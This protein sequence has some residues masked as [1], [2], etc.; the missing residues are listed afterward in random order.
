MA[1]KAGTSPATA[2]ELDPTARVPRRPVTDCPRRGRH[3]DESRDPDIMRAALELLAETGYDRLTMEAVAARAKAGKATLYRRWPSKAELVV[4]ALSCLKGPAHA[5]AHDTGSLGG[6]LRASFLGVY[7]D[8]DEFRIGVISGLLTSL[9]RNPDLAKVFEERF[10]TESMRLLRQLFARAR[11]RGEVAD[12]HDIELLAAVG[13]AIL[14]HR[15]LLTGKPLTRDFI[16]RVIDEVIL[17][18]AGNPLPGKAPA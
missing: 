18:L 1:T 12:G 4:D 7:E 14:F 3:L 13:P 17:P 2:P 9:R 6:D 8:L 16:G 5:V 11:E 10:V 15:L